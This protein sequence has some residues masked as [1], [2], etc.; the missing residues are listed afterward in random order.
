MPAHAGA[1]AKT[2][3][4]GVLALSSLSLAQGPQTFTG[5][6]SDSM[7]ALGDHSQMKMGSNDGECATACVDAHG[8]EYVLVDGRNAYT[9]SDQRTP[10]KLAGKKVRVVGT[11]DARTKRITVDS[12]GAAE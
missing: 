3:L 10:A 1:I 2:T 4:A 6:V 8:A 9:L 12:I 5:V 11:L 7:C